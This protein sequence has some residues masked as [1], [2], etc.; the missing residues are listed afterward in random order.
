MFA[1]GRPNTAHSGRTVHTEERTRGASRARRVE[2]GLRF[3]TRRDKMRRP[4]RRNPSLD[5][6]PLY[7]RFGQ[8]CAS[9][10]RHVDSSKQALPRPCPPRHVRV[11]LVR[12]GRRLLLPTWSSATGNLGF[13]RDCCSRRE[14]SRT[15]HCA[16]GSGQWG[17]RLRTAQWQGC[18]ESAGPD[19]GTVPLLPPVPDQ[20]VQPAGVPRSARSTSATD[21][22]CPWC[23]EGW[24]DNDQVRPPPLPS[25]FRVSPG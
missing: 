13:D 8:L 9:S 7:A 5:P 20:S 1:R 10:R 12:G 18:R 19:R 15:R 21:A 3:E 11:A 25:S 23:T 6:P 2:S 16:V 22:C 4:R 24:A 17:L 14:R